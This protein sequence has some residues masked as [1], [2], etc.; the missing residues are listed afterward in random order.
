MKQIFTITET[1]NGV[2]ITLGDAALQNLE[3]AKGFAESCNRK[4]LFSVINIKNDAGKVLA[5][6]V[7][8]W[9]SD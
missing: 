5:S 4:Y 8:D 6:K 1:F 9:G 7:V 2:E 3:Q